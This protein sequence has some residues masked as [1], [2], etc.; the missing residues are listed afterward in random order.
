MHSRTGVIVKVMVCSAAIIAPIWFSIQMAWRQSMTAEQRQL[1]LTTSHV[2]HHSEEASQQFWTAYGKVRDAHLQPCSPAEMD[3]MRAVTLGS[4]HI[5]TMG[6][7]Q[8]DKLICTSQGIT[9]PIQLS[10][11]DVTTEFGAKFR[12]NVR[13]A[14]AGNYPLNIASINGIALL[15]D[16]ISVLDSPVEGQDVSLATFLPSSPRHLLLSSWGRPIRPEWLKAISKGDELTFADGDYVLCIMRSSHVDV[17]VITVAPISYVTRRVQRFALIFVPVGLLCSGLIAWAAL[18]ISRRRLSMPSLLRSAARNSEFY[19]EYQPI[20]ELATRRWVGAEALV[21]WHCGNR[22]VRPALFIPIAEETGVITLIT[23]RVIELVGSD[24]PQM[25]AIDPNFRVTI[26][27]SAADL[28]E[29]KTLTYLNLATAL[30]GM[31]PANIQVEATERSFLQGEEERNLIAMIRARGNRVAIDNF[32]IGYSSL[33]CLQT[34]PLDSLKIDKSFVDAIGTDGVTS[35]V[36]LHIIAMA[37][38]LN[39]DMV[40]EGVETEEQAHF[41]LQHGVQYAQGWLFGRPMSATMLC[42]SLATQSKCDDVV[43]T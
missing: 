10:P 15:Y 35:H 23:K 16:P 7:I 33:S 12:L 37:Q 34:L 27:L 9:T 18:Y 40:T 31:S 24:L 43:L 2:L 19:V 14:I 3:L 32:G 11:I 5:L 26:N 22:I 1:H 28:R 13:L 21:R 8:G 42:A 39:F 30:S 36:I 4:P 41:L 25:I 6:R 20:V 38:S 29:C 17:A